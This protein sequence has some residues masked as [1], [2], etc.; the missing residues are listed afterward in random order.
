VTGDTAAAA[1]PRISPVV[2][3][4]VA[5]HLLWAGAFLAAGHEARDFVKIGTRFVLQSHASEVIGFDPTYRYPPN[6]DSPNGFGFDGQWSY[7]LALDP[8]NAHHYLDLPAFR[9]VRILYP[10]AARALAWG[11]PALVPW[12]LIAVNLAAIAGG[13]AALAAWLR[14]R[15]CS[16]WFALLFGL[17]PGLL[18]SFQRDLT[19]PLAYALVA[20]AVLVLD[21]GGRRRVLWAA[22]LFGLAGL[23][24]QTTAV[25][26]LCYV[27]TVLLA[28][29]GARANAGR[30]LAFLAL[31]LGP[32]L[33][34]M[35]VLWLWLGSPGASAPGNLAPPFVGILDA[36]PWQLSRQPP[37][38][39]AVI[40]PA[41]LVAGA[42]VAAWRTVGIRVE[43][44]CLLANVVLFVVLLGPNPYRSYTS[45]GRV[46]MG[47]VVASVLAVPWFAALD[48][49]LRAPLAVAAALALCLWPVVAVYGFTDVRVGSGVI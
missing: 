21:A 19:E 39:V 3:L 23:A 35:G 10:L 15:S 24:R 44:V 14:R 25:F 6:H 9:S 16:P 2:A 26:P 41:L 4:V 20:V 49:R 34:W 27:A 8:A 46:A 7:Y 13:V 33:A 22:L 5:L 18:V 29:E 37:E 32:L 12:T 43:L 38:I 40:V 36:G 30:A 45:S 42:A 47:V 48:R 17:Y 11:R 1:R 31:A 28:G